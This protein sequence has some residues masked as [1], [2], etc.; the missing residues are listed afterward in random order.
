MDSKW[1]WSLNHDITTSLGLR[2]TPI[3]VKSSPDLH[4]PICPST[5]YQ[6]DNTLYIHMIWMWDAI[7]VGLQPRIY[8]GGRDMSMLAQNHLLTPTII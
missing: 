8:L 3:F 5:A 7:F 6:G 2:P 1:V 4:R